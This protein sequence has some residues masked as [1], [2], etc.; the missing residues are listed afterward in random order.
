[1]HK[2]LEYS[3]A[4]LFISIVLGLMLSSHY[5]NLVEQSQLPEQL[6]N[7]AGGLSFRQAVAL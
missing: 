5:I 2:W 6:D 4:V 3:L 7:G 1:M